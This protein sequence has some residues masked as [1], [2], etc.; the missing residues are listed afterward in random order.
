MFSHFQLGAYSPTV[1]LMYSVGKWAVRK[2]KAAIKKGKDGDATEKVVL[3]ATKEQLPDDDDLSMFHKVTFSP[4][5]PSSFVMSTDAD[6]DMSSYSESDSS[7]EEASLELKDFLDI[8]PAMESSSLSTIVRTRSLIDLREKPQPSCRLGKS[9]SL[10]SLAMKDAEEKNGGEKQCPCESFAQKSSEDNDT[11]TGPPASSFYSTPT[12]KKGKSREDLQGERPN[13][14]KYR[15]TLS[16]PNVNKYSSMSSATYDEMSCAYFSSEEEYFGDYSTDFEIKE[17][18]TIAPSLTSVVKKKNVEGKHQPMQS[19]S[20]PSL[21]TW[22]SRNFDGNLSLLTSMRQKSQSLNLHFPVKQ[23]IS[24]PG[25]SRPLSWLTKNESKAASS[26]TRSP[27][28][29][30]IKEWEIESWFP[31]CT[32]TAPQVLQRRSFSEP[33]LGKSSTIRLKFSYSLPKL[34]S[35]SSGYMSQKR[36]PNP[37]ISSLLKYSSRLA[38]TGAQI[39]SEDEDKACNSTAEEKACP[40]DT[41]YQLVTVEQKACPTT[42][43][44]QP[45]TINEKAHSTVISV[46]HF[47][48]EEKVYPTIE[49]AERVY[50]EEETKEK[51]SSTNTSAQPTTKGK[52]SST[53]TSSQPTTKGKESSTNTSSQPTTKEKESSTNT[54]SQPTTKGKESSTNTSAQPTTK[55]K[56]SSTNTSSQPTT[57]GKESSTNTSAQPTTKKKESSTNS[58]DADPSI[59][60]TNNKEIILQPEVPKLGGL[61]GLKNSKNSC[62]LNAV[63]QCV[64][65]TTKLTDYF[66]SGEAKK[67]PGYSSKIIGAYNSF[68]KDMWMPKENTKAVLPRRIRAALTPSI[69]ILQ[70]NGQ[71]DAQEFLQ[72]LLPC[73]HD[74]INKP[75]LDS[76][77]TKALKR[78]NGLISITPPVPISS[79]FMKSCFSEL[80][81]GQTKS[82]LTC[83][84]CSRTSSSVESFWNLSLPLPTKGLFSKYVS[85]T[86]SDCFRLFAAEEKLI[87]ENRPRCS[88]CGTLQNFSKKL[89][90]QKFPESFILHL[91]RFSFQDGHLVKLTSA[92]KVPTTLS[93]KEI[94]ADKESAKSFYY[95]L[96]GVIHHSGYLDGGHYQADC[97]HNGKWYNF[98]D[99]I[100]SKKS[101][102]EITVPSSSPYLLFYEKKQFEVKAS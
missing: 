5:V 12:I 42:S 44:V 43:S 38:V 98:N 24:F 91:K 25:A 72:Y 50:I 8:S 86:L 11:C 9:L 73:L 57:K 69:D 28:I 68:L 20:L 52:K 87:K 97:K 66:L 27:P 23:N 61:I 89:E 70:E 78:N 102:A 65:H 59:Q 99:D 7:L 60:S 53:N 51:E 77:R 47:T 67:E 48:V 81:M 54:S 92:V 36:S 88:K 4:S 83:H 94:A 95:E 10:P 84:K 55:E 16:L 35:F 17:A 15:W 82:S 41:K 13:E 3:A 34:H 63:L 64:S 2:V 1:R 40:T 30:K 19:F 80:F 76:P 79:E 46:R 32:A 29:W 71:E 90:V 49:T 18:V 85:F 33:Y 58:K 39:F 31:T 26:P 14:I 96:Y 74:H 22:Q 93:V 100:V 37:S 21:N 45:V 75:P 101:T 6:D 56:D 62:Y